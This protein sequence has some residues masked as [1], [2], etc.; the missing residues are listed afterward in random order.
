[1]FKISKVFTPSGCK[2]IGIENLSLLH[3]NSTLIK[4]K[5]IELH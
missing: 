1:M 5:K 3:K 4:E 2:D